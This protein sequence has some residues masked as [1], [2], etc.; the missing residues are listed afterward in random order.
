[1]P[2]LTIDRLSLRLSGINESESRRLAQMIAEGLAGANVN[3][4]AKNFRCIQS[5][6]PAKSDT[7]LQAI[8]EGI[9]ADLIRQL[10]RS[11]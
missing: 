10:E 8:S 5:N 11:A 3:A 2:D 1:M 6:V 7:N 4:G 9:V